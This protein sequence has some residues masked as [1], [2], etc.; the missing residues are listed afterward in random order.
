MSRNFNQAT[1]LVNLV[2]RSKTSFEKITLDLM[3]ARVLKTLK[4]LSNQPGVAAWVFTTFL[5][6]FSCTFSFKTG[7]CRRASTSMLRVESSVR[8]ICRREIVGWV[9]SLLLRHTV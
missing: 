8:D 5:Q 3:T 7:A 6:R 9:S 4:P 2:Q 1:V